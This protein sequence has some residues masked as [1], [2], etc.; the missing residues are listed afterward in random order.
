MMAR[1]KRAAKAA[2]ASLAAEPPAAVAPRMVDPDPP[3]YTGLPVET[4]A[5]AFQAGAQ[6]VGIDRGPEAT[7]ADW[8]A[9]KIA[10]VCGKRW[11]MGGY[12][13]GVA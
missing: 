9:V 1:I 8:L 2:A 4:M 6:D 5:H 10:W 3:V 12:R 11:A 7:D 13:S